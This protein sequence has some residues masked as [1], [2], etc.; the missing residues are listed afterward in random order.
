MAVLVTKVPYSRKPAVRELQH[1]AWVILNSARQKLPYRSR[2]DFLEN[3]LEILLGQN[4]SIFKT[5]CFSVANVS[6]SRLIDGQ[7]KLFMD[8]EDEVV[9]LD[10]VNAIVC[11]RQQL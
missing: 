10:T 5:N 8:S 2:S 7:L 3:C 1:Q 9:L 4:F 6:I 11:S